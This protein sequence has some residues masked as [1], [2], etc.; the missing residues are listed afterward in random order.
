M[1]AWFGV[2]AA[3]LALFFGS[4]EW[5][6]RTRVEPSDLG[7][8]HRAFFFASGADS[9]GAVFGDSH[10]AR[11]FTG[12]AG[13]ANLA[14]PGEVLDRTREKIALG[15]QRRV[16][17]QVGPHAFAAYRQRIS[18]DPYRLPPWW[19]PRIREE[20]HR[21]N[22]FRYWGVLLSGGSFVPNM[23]LQPDGAQTQGESEG[24]GDDVA[25][26]AAG[27]VR[28][29]RPSP[30][31]ASTRSA[32]ALEAILEDLAKRHVEVCVTSFPVSPAYMRESARYPEFERAIG[33]LGEVTR[34]FGVVYFDQRARFDDSS[35]FFNPDH[36]TLE[37]ARRFAPLCVEACFGKEALVDARR[38]VP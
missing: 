24:G 36:L 1:V 15:H 14:S 6:I 2:T 5:L 27:R 13:F 17:L 4:T 23:E 28:E 37:G 19:D 18:P 22:W 11:G 35:L 30:D 32:A 38:A 34:R 26:L 16:I 25:R 21:S 3:A 31:P 9:P 33:Y 29:Q 12:V 20:D 7:Q 8:R 10:A